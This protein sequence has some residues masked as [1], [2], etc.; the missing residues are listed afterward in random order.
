MA[1]Q[2]RNLPDK[3]PGPPVKYEAIGSLSAELVQALEDH[4]DADMRRGARPGRPPALMR[5]DLRDQIVTS[6]K[7]GNYAS[8]AAAAA[9]INQSTLLDWLRVGRRKLNLLEAGD[10]GV[11]DL[12]GMEAAAVVFSGAVAQAV[13]YAEEK[14]LET[15]DNLAEKGSAQAAIWRMQNRFSGRWGPRARPDV[16]AE[17]T[18][19]TET[20][21]AVATDTR[22][23]H[24]R[25][26][27]AI[28]AKK[29]A[30]ETKG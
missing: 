3:P 8:T 24:E 4:A 11:G 21:E 1:K 29:T 19:E 6:I 28:A 25:L 23:P 7:R 9:G 20:V 27:A 14:M 5:R 17:E 30:E 18:E 15:I 26:L 2:R 16:T 10:V 12:T 22:T 13:S